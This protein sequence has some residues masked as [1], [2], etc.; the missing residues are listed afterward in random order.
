[1]KDIELETLV[2]WRFVPIPYG[3]KGPKEKD[4]QKKHRTLVQ[5]PQHSNIGVILGPASNGLLA[6]DFDGPWAWEYWNEHIKIPFDS[7]DT[8]MWTSN[9]PGRCQMAFNVPVEFWEHMPT[10]FS[11]SGPLGDDG[12]RQQLEFR[13]GND[14]A[15]FQ[16]VLPPSLHPDNKIDSSINYTWLRSPSEVDVCEVPMQLL[17]WAILDRQKEESVEL[18]Q[19]IEYIPKTY[20]G[21]QANNLAKK[22]KE[23]YPTL[24]YDTWIRVTWGFCNSIGY[25]DGITI[26]K[27]YYPESKV[28]EYKS[29]MSSKPKGKICTIGTVKKL[30]KDIEGDKVIKYNETLKEIELIRKKLKEKNFAR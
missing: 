5:I 30:I 20:D 28:G 3:E 11:K 18:I 25:D 27:Y 10:K 21:D 1:M 29:L 23:Y 4:W 6:I 9:K 26:M 17:E 14:D 13:W 19:G 15:G 16:S 24:D 8:V 22:L 12:K 2:D 7:F